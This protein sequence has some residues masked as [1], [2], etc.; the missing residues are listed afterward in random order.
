M[1]SG[2]PVLLRIEKNA[3]HVG[4]DAVKKRVEYVTDE[5]SFLFAELGMK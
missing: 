3:G 4:G 1:P 2:R 5:Y